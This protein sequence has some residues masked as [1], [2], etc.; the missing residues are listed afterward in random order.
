MSAISGAVEDLSIKTQPTEQAMPVTTKLK[1]YRQ[2]LMTI[3]ARMLYR[4]QAIKEFWNHL[5]NGTFP[6]RMKS[7]KPYPKVSSPEAQAIVNV[8]V[9]KSNAWIKWFKKKRKKLSQD[10]DSYQTLKDQ[11]Q[12]DRQ[13]FKTPKKPK[14]PT[15]AQNLQELAELQSKY[16]Q[17][18]RKLETAS[19]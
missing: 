18:C 6:Q 5:K 2:K 9:I 12:G 4:E 16:T 17:L 7:T 1:G 8:L 11:R 10:Q 15:V 3:K 14:K 19:E 13:K